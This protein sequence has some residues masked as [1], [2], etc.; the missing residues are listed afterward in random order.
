MLRRLRGR[1]HQV[2]TALAVLRPLDGLL[3][4]DLCSTDVR[5]RDYTDEEI[6]AY[7]ASGDPL[8]K[9]GA[10]A[11][12]HPGFHPVASICGCYPSVMGLPVCRVI[13]LVASFGVPPQ[14]DITR[15]CL[16][17]LDAP[18]RVYQAAADS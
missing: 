5:M 6:D 11:I 12:Q 2:L 9:A 7:V 15:D 16:V 4:A 8:D 10:Y 13:R 3:S 17:Q 14:A 1:T 18:C